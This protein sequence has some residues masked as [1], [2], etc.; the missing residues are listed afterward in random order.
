[1]IADAQNESQILIINLN[2][3]KITGDEPNECV[4]HLIVCLYCQAIG[5]MLSS[6]HWV[7]LG[8][9]FLTLAFPL[10]DNW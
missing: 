7:K 3:I 4:T 10:N 6:G 8:T 2:F 1:M 5:I 9:T